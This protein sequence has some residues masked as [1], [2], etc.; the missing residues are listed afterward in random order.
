M[1]TGLGAHIVAVTAAVTAEIAILAQ[2][3]TLRLL[4]GGSVGTGRVLK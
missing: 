1:A 3:Y 2:E 4:S